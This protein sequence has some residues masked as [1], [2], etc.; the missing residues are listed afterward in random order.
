[1]GKKK[2]L[3]EEANSVEE[4]DL[5]FIKD[6]LL[7]PFFSLKNEIVGAVLIVSVQQRR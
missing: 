4:E 3:L 1:M 5:Y 6:F 7:K 2:M